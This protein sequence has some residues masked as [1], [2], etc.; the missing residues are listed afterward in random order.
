VALL[1]GSPA[2]DAIGTSVVTVEPWKP[3]AATGV[4]VFLS[5][6][7]EP[8]IRMA[9]DFHGGSG[10]AGVRRLGSLAFPGD[11]TLSFRVRGAGTANTLEIKF[12]DASGENVWWAR[13]ENFSAGPDW[14]TIA[15]K[16]RHVSFAWGP[17][18]GGPFPEQAAVEIVLSKGTGGEGFLEIGEPALA[19][20]AKPEALPEPS[21]VRTSAGI[22]LDF[23][24]LRELSGLVV[25]WP[26]A[27]PTHFLVEVSSDGRAFTPVRRVTHGGARRA[28][29]HLPETEAR[30]VR[31][32]LP[33]GAW[34]TPRVAVQPV[35]WA[36]TSN[37]FVARVAKE[38][39]RGW[40]PR[41]FTG[42]QTYWTVAGVDA[43]T[44]EVL[45]GE[46]GALEPGKG[47][48]SLEPFL[49]AGGRLVSW[50]DAAIS[51]GLERGDL[52]IPTVTWKVGEVALDVT[53][54]V[55]GSPGSSVLRARYR[56]RNA[57]A[58][59]AR[60]RLVVAVRPFLVNPPTQFLNAPHG[61][62]RID[63]LSFHGGTLT[64]NGTR[65]VSAI[66]APVATGVAAFDAGP[67]TDF[68]LKGELPSAGEIEDETG[69]A[70]GAFAW[71][72]RARCA[73]R[74]P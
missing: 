29:L 43:D 48:F 24:D 42:E 64:V 14:Q 38:A 15:V 31:L 13:R 30:F 25:D 61:V 70:S 39:P 6:L 62:S 20:R 35:E 36:P 40:Y 51:H 18:G 9:Y 4:D 16:K 3:V 32:A 5:S 23:G 49:F 71:D 22:L 11:W 73:G 7:G 57:G 26:A 47:T 65:T 10:W 74:H 27:V 55:D 21:V 33:P 12:L 17:A 1:A 59:A 63:S 66:P 41:A 45:V 19:V 50:N 56:V 2:R 67:M 72:P 68:L 37:D 54:L 28:W 44:E 58:A 53:A 52:P 60:V 69:L 8:G 34:G 46:D